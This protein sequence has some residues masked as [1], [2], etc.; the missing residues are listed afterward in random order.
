MRKSIEPLRS[1]PDYSDQRHVL[2]EKK[3][4]IY[5][6]DEN[7]KPLTVDKSRIASCKEMTSYKRHM[8]FLPKIGEQI[9]VSD[10]NAYTVLNIVH[11]LPILQS[12]VQK[13]YIVLK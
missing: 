10:K 13:V 11:S 1:A 4:T 3:A 8:A 9:L 6:V 12:D 7:F 5:F 2:Q